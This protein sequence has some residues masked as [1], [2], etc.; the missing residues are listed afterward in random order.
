M[1]AEYG[2]IT[3]TRPE[4]FRVKTSGVAAIVAIES[5]LLRMKAN[6]TVIGSR[7]PGDRHLLPEQ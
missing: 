6:L 7:G 5:S 1:N 2:D 4:A 3:L